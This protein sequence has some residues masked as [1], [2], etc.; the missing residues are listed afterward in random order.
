MSTIAAD[1]IV[2]VVRA[3]GYVVD[4]ILETHAAGSQ[5]RSAAWYLRMQLSISQGWSPQLCNEAT[6]AGLEAMWQ[7]KYGANNKFSTSIR[8]GLNDGE[9]LPF[10][11]LSLTCIHLPGV[12]TPHRR[13]YHVGREVFGA[14]SIATMAEDLRDQEHVGVLEPLAG[15]SERHLDAWTSVRGLLSLHGDT[16]VWRDTGD[17]CVIEQT[18]QPFDLLSQCAAWKEYAGLAKA[19]FLT[20]RREAAK[21]RSSTDQERPPSCKSNGGLRSRWQSWLRA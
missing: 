21:I 17:D 13:A 14:H 18:S 11:G 19:D 3:N 16:R 15:E 6:V 2:E 9:V 10:G 4:Y 8:T 5:C 20:K 1:A 7:R 12:S